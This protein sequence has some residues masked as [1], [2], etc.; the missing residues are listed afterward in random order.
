MR[1]IWVINI[2]NVYVNKVMLSHSSQSQ[3]T[4]YKLMAKIASGTGRFCLPHYLKDTVHSVQH[5]DQ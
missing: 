2:N 3:W 4:L 5:I 1:L